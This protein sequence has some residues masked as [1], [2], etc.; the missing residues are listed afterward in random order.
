MWVTFLRKKWT[1]GNSTWNCRFRF[2]M[3]WS[4]C[5]PNR[6]LL[7]VTYCPCW[8]W[9]RNWVRNRF[10]CRSLRNVWLWLWIRWR[11]STR[12]RMGRSWTRFIRREIVSW[13][14]WAM[15]RASRWRGEIIFIMIWM[16]M[17]STS[18]WRISWRRILSG[19]VSI[20]SR[21]RVRSPAFPQIRKISSIVSCI[22]FWSKK[23]DQN[24]TN[25]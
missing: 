7:S 2:R 13:G 14:M 21:S 20:S 10:L 11:L 9:R 19:S 24:L 18:S 12:V 6:W 17:A 8:T 3:Q 15:R 4:Q 16:S 23:P 22:I 5:W 25:K 1:L